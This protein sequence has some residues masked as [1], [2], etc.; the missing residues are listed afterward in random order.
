MTLERRKQVLEITQRHG[1]PIFE[2][3]CY[4]DLRF[5]GDD[6]TSFHSLDDTGSVIYVGSF[7]KIVAP[8]MR[9]G[10]MVAPKE[11]IH[12]A[13]SFKAGGGVNQF[14]ALAIEEY[15]KENMYQHIQDENQ[16]L[17]VKRDAMIASLGENLGTAAKW[18]VPQGG[19]YV[20]VEFPEGTDLAGFQEQS[21][22]EGVGFYNGTQF[23]PDGRGAHLA[24]L[25][26]GHPSAE[27]VYEGVA[28]WARILDRNGLIT[29]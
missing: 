1:I 18:L 10:Y 3:D 11:V 17:V 28:E 26:F 2:D 24:R 8:G 9:M 19:L 5:E 21:F 23:S 25:C 6:V 16:A 20:W 4:V 27:T 13:M 7:S 14:A 12:R 22:R 15:L 29:G